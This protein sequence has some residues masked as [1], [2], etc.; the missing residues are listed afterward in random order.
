MSTDQTL[1]DVQ[2]GGRVGLGNV[3]DRVMGECEQWFDTS[4]VDMEA[5]TDSIIAAAQNSL[6]G[7]GDALKALDDMAAFCSDDTA[8]VDRHVAVIRAA[9][10]A[11]QPVGEPVCPECTTPLLYEC[12]GCS[13]M[14][15]PEPPQAVDLGAVRDIARKAFSVAL[16]GSDVD[17]ELKKLLAVIDG[18]AVGK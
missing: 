1:A 9:L 18:K 13:K 12:P 11:R 5:A 16:P 6:G 14:N 17:A 7:Q 3:R 10:A 2:P 4:D 8:T 15:Y